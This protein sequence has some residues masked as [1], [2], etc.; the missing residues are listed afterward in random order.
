MNAATAS[1]TRRF[2][3]RVLPLGLGLAFLATLACGGDKAAA[4]VVP[5]VVADTQAPSVPTGLAAS[6]IT[7]AGLTLTW[8]ASTDNIAVTGYRVYR[9]AATTPIATVPSGVTYNDTGLTAN[10]AYTY[11]VDA[12]D[13]AGN[14]SAKT[15]VVNV[16]TASTVPTT[17]V[18]S[19]F[20]ASPTTITAGGSS[21]LAWTVTG[22]TSLSIANSVGTAIGTVTGTS[23]SVTPSATTIYTLTATN[24]AGNS[25]ATAT[26]TV[27]PV[28]TDTTPPSAPTNLAAANISA[29]GLT[30]NWTASTDNVA[31]TGYRVYRG[32]ATA[33][34]ATV[35]GTTYNA[36]GLTAN[37]AYTFTVAAIDGAVNESQPS[38]ALA[39][40][41]SNE[42]AR[43]VIAS[44][45][46]SPARIVA[47]GTSTLSWS[48]SGATSLVLDQ[49]IG[50]VT[51]TRTVSPTTTIAYRLTAT[52]AAGNVNASV[53]VV[54]DGTNASPRDFFIDF[55][56]GQDTA[57]GTST[58]TPW[59]HA[60]G[61]PQA[62]GQP[63]SIVLKG[64]DRVL[65][66]SGVVY[67]GQIRIPASGYPNQPI[68]Y[69]GDAWGTGK[70][71]LSGAEAITTWR[72]ATSAA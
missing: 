43:P 24:A 30:L 25:T 39:V 53:L 5:P 13:A 10:T 60:P 63:R 28:S 48:V 11:A 70:A 6:A 54:V 22:A 34:I 67:R 40:T 7:A 57:L 16:T 20:T 49:G 32:T 37:T 62:T 58:A 26:V 4:Q 59:K 51:N 56:A 45:T 14:A 3:H 15:S 1:P 55:E 42:A 21:T 72:R 38:A 71:I 35:T 2:L 65:F 18:I 47:G 46:A 29:T 66:K 9:N 8:T 52:N 33:P 27:T 12:I 31:V 17:P 69:K 50:S 23:L 44:F 41:T 36:S 19:A 68:T 61:D 64:G